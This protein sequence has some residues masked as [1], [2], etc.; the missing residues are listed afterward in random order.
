MGHQDP[1]L[2][3]ILTQAHLIHIQMEGIPR[4]IRIQVHIQLSDILIT[5]LIQITILP[6]RQRKSIGQNRPACTRR[7]K[8]KN[9]TAMIEEITGT[10]ESIMTRRR[11]MIMITMIEGTGEMEVKDK[12]IKNPWITGGF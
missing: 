10:M 7:D 2:R 5:D 4:V 11:N 12:P 1:L 9:M 6:D 3:V 8:E